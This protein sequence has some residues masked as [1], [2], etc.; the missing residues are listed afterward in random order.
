[1]IDPLSFTGPGEATRQLC[2]LDWAVSPLGP[3]DAWPASFRILLALVLSS[4]EAMWFAWGPERLFF[5]NDAYVPQLGN[6]APGAIGSPFGE[7]WADVYGEVRDAID[8]TFA[9]EAF[10]FTERPL[11]MDRDGEGLVETFWTFAFSPVRSERGEVVAVLCTAMEET[12][13]RERT[14][15][16]AAA[17]RLYQ[18]IVH[19]D[20]NPVCAFNRDHAVIAFNEAF[21]DE[22]FRVYGHRAKLGDTFPDLFLPDQGVLIESYLDRAM[23]GEAFTVT[24]RFGHPDHAMPMWEISY[25]P[26]RDGEGRII[27]TVQHG[28][29]V[30]DQTIA[31]EELAQAQEQLRQSQ[32][33]DAIGQLT[34]GVAHDFNN[35]LTVIRGSVDLLR[36]DNLPDAKRAR[37][38]DAIGDTADRAAKLT[39]QLLAFARRQALKSEVFDAGVSLR[40]VATM[41]QTMTG[42]RIVLDIKV[43]EIA[44]FIDADRSQFDT[45]IVNMGI[46][47][48][49]AMGG[50]G[51]LTIATGPVSGIPALRGHPARI[52]DFVAFTITD[53]GSG[54]P[55]E[56]VDR[57]FEPFFTTKGV[58]EGTGLGLSQVIGFA[59]QSGGDISVS[60][61]PDRG[62]TFTMYMPRAYP[63]GGEAIDVEAIEQATGEGVCVLVVE[64]NE[65]VGEFAIAAL[66]EIGFDTVLATDGHA[67]L[68]LL[69]ENCSRFHVIFSDV[70]MPGMGGI[71]LGGEVR[72]LYPDVPIVLTSG[73]SHVL[74]Q[75]GQHGFELL[76]KPY[77]VEQLSHVLHKAITWQARKRKREP[78][79]SVG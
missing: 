47:A 37:Y 76:H 43:P 19:S 40:E 52:G 44:F 42:S 36:R 7:V 18:D 27:G 14:R 68:K 48:R 61:V 49:D 38:I 33:L 3:A 63:D 58:G 15:E 75:N 50:E 65:Q 16:D 69:G 70:V 51:H 39:G 12:Q 62:T 4:P 32:K 1:M 73:Y 67:A 6:K 46:N 57:I 60:S 11:M 34:G 20:P 35:L 29:D 31:Q 10:K 56:V 25:N 77:S 5:F 2:A 41:V 28:V 64:D 54:I 8:R 24:E 79:R 53:T 9:G 30:D 78:A 21:S 55:A 74:A 22:F 23:A 66:R 71:E 72:R 59:K 45:A 26:L 17:L 13:R